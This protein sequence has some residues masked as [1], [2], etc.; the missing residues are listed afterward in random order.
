AKDA[1]EAPEP[2]TIQLQMLPILAVGAG[3][4]FTP[5]NRW[6][7]SWLEGT[8]TEEHA[9]VIVMI[10]STVV[11]LLGIGLGWLIYRQ[12]SIS[13]DAIASSAPWLTKLL[14]NKYYIDEVYQVIIVA[15]LRAIGLALSAFDQ[16]IVD[17][18]VRGVAGLTVLTGR[19]S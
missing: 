6:C 7:A 9:N 8:E 17:G 11:G 3:F 1:D 5:F 15:P 16:W 4:G 13:R 12:K 14:A 18:I 2:M 19:T 10:L